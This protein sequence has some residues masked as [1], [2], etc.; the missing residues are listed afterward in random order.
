MS[1]KKIY[2]DDIQDYSDEYDYDEYDEPTNPNSIDPN[3]LTKYCVNPIQTDSV[4]SNIKSPYI[5]QNND[6]TYKTREPYN[7]DIHFRVSD[8]FYKCPDSKHKKYWRK[9]KNDKDRFASYNGKCHINRAP[10]EKLLK[11]KRFISTRLIMKELSKKYKINI[12]RDITKI[13]TKITLKD[14]ILRAYASDQIT[15]NII[16]HLLE[17]K[18]LHNLKKYKIINN[19]DKI[20]SYCLPYDYR[21]LSF[22]PELSYE[23]TFELIKINPDIIRYINTIESDE[24]SMIAIKQ[25]GLLLSCVTN[26]TYKLCLEAVKQNGQALYYVD[27]KYKTREICLEALKQN[28]LTI[29]YIKNPSYDMIMTAVKQNGLAL[30]YCIIPMNTMCNQSSDRNNVYIA[31]VSQNGMAIQFIE[32]KHQTDEI[33]NAA[34]DNTYKAINYIT[35]PSNEICMKAIIQNPRMISY[36]GIMI[37]YEDVCLEAIKRDGRMLEYLDKDIRYVN[38]KLEHFSHMKEIYCEIAVQQTG[39]AL[40]YVPRRFLTESLC[41]MAIKQTYHAY[42]HVCQ[43]G[44]L[45]E[46]NLKVAAINGLVLKYIPVEQQTEAVCLTAIKQ[47]IKAFKYLIKKYPSVLKYAVGV[48]CF[49]LRFIINQTEEICKHAVSQNGYAIVHAK[50]ATYN[51]CLAAVQQNVGSLKYI[52]GDLYDRMVEYINDNNL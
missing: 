6:I 49:L 3:L 2:Y 35:N 51:V 44:L 7:M 10:Q 30:E 19:I 26:I 20:K 29:S 8:N 17:N 16:L 32:S 28:G 5:S 52:K 1:Y 23:E 31:A 24:I 48:D 41:V 27:N 18:T 36:I 37:K 42:K 45:E 39:I 11:H 25:N 4:Q 34:I 9:Y 38:G 15:R 22:V 43:F 46:F 12:S 13:I 14:D 21:F 47:N 50:I 33:R 40:K